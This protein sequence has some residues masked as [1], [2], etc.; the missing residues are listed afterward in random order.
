M[1]RAADARRQSGC[2]P[3]GLCCGRGRGCATLANAEPFLDAGAIRPILNL[4][5]LHPLG[6]PVSEHVGPMVVEPGELRL[7][8]RYAPVES[9]KV[10]FL[11]SPGRHWR[12]A[13]SEG[14]SWEAFDAVPAPVADTAK[15]AQS[16]GFGC[17]APGSLATSLAYRR[18][19]VAG[20]VS[21]CRPFKRATASKFWSGRGGELQ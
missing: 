10:A 21:E 8:H 11:R 13:R 15:R 17:V 1:E 19:G 9:V 2:S 5:S 3:D 14:R 4:A 16:A 6:R 7:H 18:Y 12:R 20:T